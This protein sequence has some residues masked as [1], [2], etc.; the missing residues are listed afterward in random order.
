MNR[1]LK[2]GCLSVGLMLTGITLIIAVMIFYILIEKDCLGYLKRAADSNTVK[3]AVRN[4][5]V[6][7]EYMDSHHLTTGYTSVIYNTPDEDIGFWYENITSARDSLKAL[8][9][10]ATELEKSNALMKLR[11]TLLD[12]GESGASVTSPN[13]ISKYPHNLFWG[14]ALFLGILFAVGGL[15]LILMWLE[16]AF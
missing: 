10:N 7:I 4:L 14:L 2:I 8:P 9:N 12:D 16:R 13:G 3:L 1:N 6:A 11:E 5:N 15:V